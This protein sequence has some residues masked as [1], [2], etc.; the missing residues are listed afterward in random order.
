ME[1]NKIILF[2]SFSLIIF[3]NDT[4]L[5][6]VILSTMKIVVWEY[7]FEALDP[8]K[9]CAYTTSSGRPCARNV[10]ISSKK[11]VGGFDAAFKHF[12]L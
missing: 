2:V 6:V 5:S 9:L 3:Q 1:H 10:L 7:L 4:I 11:N 8:N 12:E